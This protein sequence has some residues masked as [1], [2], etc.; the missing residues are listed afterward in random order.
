MIYK[1]NTLTKEFAEELIA[2][3]LSGAKEMKNKSLEIYDPE[4]KKRVFIDLYVPLENKQAVSCVGTFLESLFSSVL[5]TNGSILEIHN[6]FCSIYPILL[7]YSKN[8][9]IW[10]KLKENEISSGIYKIRSIDT[11]DLIKSLD[12]VSEHR[13]RF[14][15]KN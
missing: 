13:K 11:E 10:D 4:N 14:S 1:W 8:N 6:K 7:D 3:Y 15:P 5:E 2:L 12:E 9:P